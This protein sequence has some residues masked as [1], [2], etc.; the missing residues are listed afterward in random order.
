M[1][2][3]KHLRLP[4]QSSNL[5]ELRSLDI[6]ITGFRAADGRFG[7]SGH[8]ARACQG[9]GN[10]KDQRSHPISPEGGSIGRNF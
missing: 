10:N 2:S 6:P 3:S 4:A 1:T 9:H 8:A 7:G 5:D